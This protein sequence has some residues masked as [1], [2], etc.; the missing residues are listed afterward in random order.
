MAPEPPSD[1]PVLPSAASPSRLLCCSGADDPRLPDVVAAVRALEPAGEFEAK[2]ERVVAGVPADLGRTIRE[3]FRVEPINAGGV[4]AE[5]IVPPGA[6]SPGMLV[7]FHG[8]GYVV[9]TAGTHRRRF[10]HMAAA[11]GC[12]AL[13][14]DYRLAPEHPFPAAIED[15]VAAVRW[16][17]TRGPV[18][19]LG[20]SA[21]GGLALA[22]G[23][24]LAD[25]ADARPAGVVAISPWSDL[26]LAGRSHIERRDRD[27]FAHIDDLPAYVEC[28]LGGAT[29]PTDPLASPLF[30]DFSG[31]PPLLVQVG[32]EETMYDDAL[33]VAEKA[34][35]QGADVTFEEWEGMFHT[36]HAHVGG[37][38]GA[39]DA[40]ASIGRFVADHLAPQPRNGRARTN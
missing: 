12:L 20:D 15:A 24:A 32:S 13:N 39:D 8:G 22:A 7:C 35:C 31:Y 21:G 26:T 37:L 10:A 30:G 38:T 18:V 23:L 29:P 36:W 27:P 25:D 5:L 2:R 9:C 6:R 1:A 11:A 19:V 17:A 28:Y 34:A 33:L 4:R 14:V 3:G 16:A 40:I